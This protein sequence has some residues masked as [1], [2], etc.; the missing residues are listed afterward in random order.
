MTEYEL[1]KGKRVLLVDDE[2]DVFDTL[3]DLLPMCEKVWAEMARRR[4]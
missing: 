2:L 1:L 4:K 3:E